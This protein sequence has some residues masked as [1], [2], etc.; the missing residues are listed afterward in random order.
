M[1]VQWL[2]DRK[3][4]RIFGNAVETGKGEVDLEM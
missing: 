1:V 2:K 4:V 3:K